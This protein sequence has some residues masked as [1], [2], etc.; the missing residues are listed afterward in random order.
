MASTEYYVSEMRYNTQANTPESSNGATALEEWSGCCSV[1]PA[2]SD[3]SG[4][5]IS[6][7]QSWPRRDSDASITAI[8]TN[9]TDESYVEAEIGATR[10]TT[11]PMRLS[12]N[13]SLSGTAISLPL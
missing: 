12:D 5:P 4:S 2:V 8:D 13:V 11:G 1:A 3:A 7:G 9:E 6:D 10:S